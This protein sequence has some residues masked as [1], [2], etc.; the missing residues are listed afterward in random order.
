MQAPA[1][2]GSSE[3]LPTLAAAAERCPEN[4]IHR[5]HRFQ[6][7]R[8]MHK[9]DSLVLCDLRNLCIRNFWTKN[10]RTALNCHILVRRIRGYEHLQ[11]HHKSAYKS[12]LFNSLNRALTK[13]AQPLR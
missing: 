6:E 8:R 12:L 1:A 2:M 10:Y 11:T 5:L 13:L 3:H 9:A 7:F 4:D